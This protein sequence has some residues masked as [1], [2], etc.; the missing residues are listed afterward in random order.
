MK[1]INA[2][3]FEAQE[4]ARRA[5][6]VE[7]IKK[8]ST[9]KIIRALGDEWSVYRQKLDAAGYVDQF[10]AANYLASNDPVFEAFI[11]TV[12]EE[13]REKLEDCIWD[14]E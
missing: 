9:L 5:E 8:Y 4:A 10:F 1:I 14:A 12:P 2:K 3:T 13:L 7:S 6:A 11:A